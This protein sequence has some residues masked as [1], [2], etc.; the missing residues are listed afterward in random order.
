MS[1]SQTRYCVA[2][3]IRTT[4]LLTLRSGLL[5]ALLLFLHPLHLS[6]QSSV[7]SIQ[8]N[9]ALSRESEYQVEPLGWAAP[10]RFKSGAPRQIGI[11]P[12]ILVAVRSSVGA[13]V[14]TSR[15]PS[16]L[17]AGWLKR[18][19]NHELARLNLEPLP[20]LRC[21]GFNSLD[22]VSAVGSDATRCCL[23]P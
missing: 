12:L 10:V 8:L 19:A 14:L 13:T 16:T 1:R 9:P 20:I 15:L 3:H 11:A 21:C 22:S 7:G 17:A 5:V 2:R 23:A 4:R 18:A 6:A